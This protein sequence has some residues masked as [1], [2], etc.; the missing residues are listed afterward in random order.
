MKPIKA[1][2]EIIGL[3]T[4]QEIVRECSIDLISSEDLASSEVRSAVASNFMH[5]YMLSGTQQFDAYLKLLN[6]SRGKSFLSVILI[7][8]QFQRA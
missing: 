3:I 7:F 4:K 1:T 6:K 5:R 8:E 2:K